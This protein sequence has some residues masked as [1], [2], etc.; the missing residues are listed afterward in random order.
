[1]DLKTRVK[2]LITASKGVYEDTDATMLEGYKPERL[3]ALEAK[4]A[5]VAPVVKP[6]E[7]PAAVAATPA[8]VVPPVKEPTFDELLAKADPD[9]RTA[10]ESGRS[11]AAAKKTATIA[12]LKASKRCDYSDEQL[13][14][15]SQVDLDRLAKLAAVTVAT[16]VVDYSGQGAP[17]VGSERQGAPAPI[18]L[19][20][21]LAANKK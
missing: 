14:A 16:G 15:M 6:V 19:K 8:A 2:A 17:R 3:T 13:T 10:I 21:A 9:T 5:E 18:E 20:D 1:M 11:A 12:T 4:F 7:T